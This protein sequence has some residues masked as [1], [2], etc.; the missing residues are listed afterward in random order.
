MKLNREK[1]LEQL[2]KAYPAIALNPIVPHYGYFKISKERDGL[3]GSIQAYNGLV[4]VNVQLVEDI[5]HDCVVPAESFIKLLRSLEDEEVELIFEEDEVKIKTNAVKGTFTVLDETSLKT[6][7]ISGTIISDEQALQD[8]MEGLKVCRI[9]ASKDQTSGPMRGVK[10]D[11][12]KII[13][14]DRYRVVVWRLDNHIPVNCCIPLKF[15]DIVLKNRDEIKEFLFVED[16][17]FTAILNDGTQISTMLLKGEYPNVLQ[18]FPTSGSFKEIK[19]TDSIES[20]SAVGISNAIERHV[21]FLSRVD[22]IDKEITVQILKGKCITKSKDKELGSLVD[23]VDIL[24]EEDLDIEFLVNPVFL[25]DIIGA[26]S[27]FKYYDESGLILLE[28][29]KLSKPDKLQYLT[30]VRENK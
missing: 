5:G 28:A 14:T 2:E 9:Y 23:E 18:Y 4:L 10:I 12:D 21:T 11:E 16:D 13:A 3:R 30:Q 6:I 27:C 1:L 25:K 22:L 7:S 15:I 19:F 29:D 8:L 24:S 20:V 26:C 17:N